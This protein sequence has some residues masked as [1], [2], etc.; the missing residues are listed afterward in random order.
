MF[1]KKS[2][3]KRL[4]VCLLIIIIAFSETGASKS[5]SYEDLSK[6]L[7]KYPSDSIPLPDLLEIMNNYISSLSSG[8]KSSKK[9]KNT[10][11][12]LLSQAYTDTT[13]VTLGSR[14]VCPAELNLYFAEEYFDYIE[15]PSNADYLDELL[16]IDSF[17]DLATMKHGRKRETWREFFLD[18]AVKTLQRSLA[19]AKFAVENNSN[20]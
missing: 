4:F 14:K 16:A 20:L 2:L 12:E 10:P 17:S 9:M 6:A 15:D 8:K 13:A 7:K 11:E 18:R 5:N 19:L 3:P 1:K